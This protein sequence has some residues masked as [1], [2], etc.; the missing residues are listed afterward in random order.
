M[1]N[2]RDKMDSGFQASLETTIGSTVKHTLETMFG[3]K[4]DLSRGSAGSAG[5]VIAA[6]VNFRQGI[7][8]IALRLV[9][10]RAFICSLIQGVYAKKNAKMPD[11]E[12][13]N[14]AACEL[15]NIICHK[16]KFFMNSNGF[17]FFVDLPAPVP[18]NKLADGA[19]DDNIINMNFSKLEAGETASPVLC[20]NMN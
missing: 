10:E 4:I 17:M 1:P 2:I 20:V 5:D 19:A 12:M 18:A 14:D 15:A 7:E 11:D 3:C 6:S 13:C 9:F 8:V 16:I